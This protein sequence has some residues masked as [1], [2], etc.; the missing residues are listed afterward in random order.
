MPG[1]GLITGYLETLAGQLPGPVVEELADGLE[2]TYRR[3]VDADH[4]GL[5][6]PAHTVLRGSLRSRERASSTKI[7][8]PFTAVASGESRPLPGT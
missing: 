5:P 4:P 8:V 7:A 6:G 2:E 1:P 3:R